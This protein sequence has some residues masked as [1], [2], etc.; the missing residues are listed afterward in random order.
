MA[1]LGFLKKLIFIT[2][3]AGPL[4][5]KAVPRRAADPIFG[6]EQGCVCGS[7]ECVVACVQF[8]CCDY[9]AAASTELA[10]FCSIDCWIGYQGC[11]C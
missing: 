8:G 5:A 4:V 10:F 9:C 7:Y 3:F 6:P 2:I 1:T 11:C